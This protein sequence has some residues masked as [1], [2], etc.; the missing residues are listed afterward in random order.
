MTTTNKRIP[1][2]TRVRWRA[3]YEFDPINEGVVVAFVAAGDVFPG[4]PDWDKN[5]MADVY[6]VDVDRTPTGKPRKT[7]KQMRPYASRLEAQNPDKV[8]G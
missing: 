2:G 4:R 6:L 8:E 3:R 7:P 5:I 1:K